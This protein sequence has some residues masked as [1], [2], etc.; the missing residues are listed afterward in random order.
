MDEARINELADEVIRLCR[1]R[2]LTGNEIFVIGAVTNDIE[3]VER[4]GME[5]AFLVTIDAIK[6]AKSRDEVFDN[7]FEALGVDFD[8]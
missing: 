8:D 1:E 7:V 3:A 5:E 4:F 6:K 2:G